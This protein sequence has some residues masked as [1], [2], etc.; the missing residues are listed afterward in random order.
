VERPTCGRSDDIIQVREPRLVNITQP[1]VTG[2]FS[3][4]EKEE[5][6]R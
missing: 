3:E 4:E 5:V 1:L 2:A 6:S